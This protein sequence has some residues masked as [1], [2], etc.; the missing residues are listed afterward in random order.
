MNNNKNKRNV[1]LG[2]AIIYELNL[3]YVMAF[4]YLLPINAVISNY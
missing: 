4:C 2:E 3:D 1:F